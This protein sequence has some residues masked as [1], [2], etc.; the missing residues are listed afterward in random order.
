[1]ANNASGIIN[2]TTLRKIEKTDISI[3]H[4]P[5]FYHTSTRTARR[6]SVRVITGSTTTHGER[7]SFTCGLDSKTMV[8][9]AN[10][11]AFAPSIQNSRSRFR[12]P[13]GGN[14]SQH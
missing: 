1:M 11:A 14:K 10:Q 5:R 13:S 3:S 8:R 4:M 9:F 2:H 7:T 12:I 6:D